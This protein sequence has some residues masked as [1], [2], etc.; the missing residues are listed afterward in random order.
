MIFT[1][2]EDGFAFMS[3]ELNVAKLK[4]NNIVKFNI[5]RD[6]EPQ[7]NDCIHVYKDGGTVSQYKII[8]IIESRPSN[9]SGKNYITARVNH[10]F[11]KLGQ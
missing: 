4:T 3:G 6:I 2:K 11:Q 5:N 7:I 1:E 8:E 9:M 10:S